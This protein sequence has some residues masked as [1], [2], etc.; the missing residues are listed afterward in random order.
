MEDSGRLDIHLQDEAAERECPH[1]GPDG[2]ACLECRLVSVVW[3]NHP[4]REMFEIMLKGLPPLNKIG[5][6]NV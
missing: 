3:A 2:L 1:V 6:K 5:E 4:C